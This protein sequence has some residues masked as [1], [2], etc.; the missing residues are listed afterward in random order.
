MLKRE[1]VCTKVTDH[2]V[3]R[4]NLWEMSSKQI[5]VITSQRFESLVK[6]GAGW[7]SLEDFNFVS[8]PNCEKIAYIVGT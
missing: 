5:L 2:H 3:T 8:Y 1:K 4:S 6:V 7:T